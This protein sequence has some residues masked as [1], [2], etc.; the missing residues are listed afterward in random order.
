M[1]TLKFTHNKMHANEGYT[2]MP[3]FIYPV[4]KSD[5]W[6]AH[7]AGEVLGRQSWLS[8]VQGKIMSHCGGNWAIFLKMKNKHS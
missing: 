4:G 5:S 1:K 7:A 3:V 8:S 6:R 2:E